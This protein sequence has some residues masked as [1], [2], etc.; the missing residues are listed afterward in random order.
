MCLVSLSIK[1]CVYAKATG[2]KSSINTR[3]R[4]FDL[5]VWPDSRGSSFDQRVLGTKGYWSPCIISKSQ[6]TLSQEKIKSFTMQTLPMLTPQR[7]VL[8]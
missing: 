5:M 2:V 3:L 7:D 4:Q 1:K 6:I 8:R